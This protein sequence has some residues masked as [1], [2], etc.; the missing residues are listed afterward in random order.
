MGKSRSV[1]FPSLGKGSRGASLGP[2]GFTHALT[3]H[4]AEL[5]RFP[6]SLCSAGLHKEAFHLYSRKGAV[7]W[8]GPGKPL[9]APGQGC[10]GGIWCPALPCYL[11]QRCSKL[12]RSPRTK[13]CFQILP[14][15]KLSHYVQRQHRAVGAGRCTLGADALPRWCR[16]SRC[17]HAPQPTPND[18][19]PPPHDAWR[20]PI[21]HLISPGFMSR[22]FSPWLRYL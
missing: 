6:I 13:I 9:W 16:Q 5:P 22:G 10:A 15:R 3:C 19:S 18:P 1:C 21:Y 8:A 14:C 12:L 2:G 4:R 11:C 20:V 7:L 17:G